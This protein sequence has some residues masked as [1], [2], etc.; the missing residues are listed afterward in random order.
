MSVRK[1]SADSGM[2]VSFAV[3]TVIHLT[4]FLLLFWYGGSIRPMKVVETYY[5]DVVNLPVAS[6]RAGSPTQQGNNSEATPPPKTPDS[7]M[8]LPQKTVNP[9]KTAAKKPETTPKKEDS[10]LFCK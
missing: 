10:S 8:N 2:R 7:P 1:S 3:S 6:P 9:A 5:V 4:V